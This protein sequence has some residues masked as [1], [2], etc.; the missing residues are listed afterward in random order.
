MTSRET[1]AGPQDATRPQTR[2][3]RTTRLRLQSLQR[4]IPDTSMFRTARRNRISYQ[5]PRVGVHSS[6]TASPNTRD[7]MQ[8]LT[9]PPEDIIVPPAAQPTRE[10]SSRHRSDRADNNLTPSS[11]HNR[12][13]HRN[14]NL[15]MPSPIAP[16]EESTEMEAESST[17]SEAAATS[18]DSTWQSTYNNQYSN[19][20]NR[21]IISANGINPLTPLTSTTSRIYNSLQAGT[22]ILDSL[23]ERNQEGIR[24]ID[25]LQER[26]R[27]NRRFLDSLGETVASTSTRSLAQAVTRRDSPIRR[28]H[29]LIPGSPSR[30]TER[31]T[32]EST[33]STTSQAST[34]W[35]DGRRYFDSSNQGSYLDAANRQSRV[36]AQNGGATNQRRLQFRTESTEQTSTRSLQHSAV[37][38]LRPSSPRRSS[39]SLMQVLETLLSQSDQETDS[40]DVQD[41]NVGPSG[42]VG[43]ASGDSRFSARVNTGYTPTRRSSTN[44][45][46]LNRRTPDRARVVRARTV[47]Q[48]PPTENYPFKDYTAAKRPK[49]DSSN[50]VSNGDVGGTNI[51]SI[52]CAICLDSFQEALF[53][54]NKLSATTCGHMF[55][56]ECIFHAVQT[57]GECPL[58]RMKLL[59]REIIQLHLG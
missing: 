3:T 8:N 42:A 38:R 6:R 11:R 29:R 43:G 33:D 52:I 27:E 7:I 5:E 25:S 15:A 59:P 4:R 1:T 23:Q 18:T 45:R 19:P 34:S 53:V 48:R 24:I 21:R 12:D 9:H 2:E 41:A 54:G 26:N 31:S 13:N 51:A 57:H 35:T 46:M 36:D 30:Q 17:A 28:A 55:C 10:A 39:L 47:R 14:A 32:R 37:N 58:C 50:A 40:E 44:N 49:L 16:L 56:H 20:N 22:R